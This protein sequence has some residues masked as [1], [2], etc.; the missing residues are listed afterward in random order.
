MQT[1]RQIGRQAHPIISQRQV[2]LSQL[3][4]CSLIS[5]GGYT[6]IMEAQYSKL[7]KPDRRQTITREY[8]AGRIKP[9]N[10]NTGCY[11]MKKLNDAYIQNSVHIILYLGVLKIDKIDC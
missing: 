6:F 7:K 1:D 9:V 3:M 11:W 8:D 2:Y 5:T 10:G 4:F